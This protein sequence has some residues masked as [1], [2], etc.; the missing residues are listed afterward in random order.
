MHPYLT[1]LGI[2]PEVQEY[3]R[4]FYFSDDSGN[5]LFNYGDGQEHYG[6]AFHHIPVSDHFWMAGNL[7]LLQVRHVILS[8]SALDALSWLNKKAI[9]LSGLDNLLFLSVGA[10]IRQSHLHWISKQL[11]GKACT[12][13]FSNDLLGRIAD[14]KLAAVLRKHPV[15]VYIDGNEQVIIS[16]RSRT[17]YFGQDSFSLNA[18]EKA[19]KYRFGICTDKPKNHL[20]FFDELKADALNT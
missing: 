11:N 6:F 13:I 8:D 5:L 10:G 2:S 16:F 14:L 17:H 4:P 20:T 15:N 9:F 7:E 1:R 3:F 19:A 12:L 18:F